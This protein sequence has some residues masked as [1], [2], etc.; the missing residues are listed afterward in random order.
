MKLRLFFLLCILYLGGQLSAADW[1]IIPV[2]ISDDLSGMHFTDE[3][4][5]FI[6][7]TSGSIYHLQKSDSGWV[8]EEQQLNRPV[9]GV[10]FD[11]NGKDG[12]AYGIKGV[13]F[14]TNDSGK[15][16]KLDTLNES[17]AFGGLT[18][19]DDGSVIL[20]G[21]DYA[22]GAGT[23]GI[24]LKST[25]KCQTWQPLNVKGK[26]F[27]SLAESPDGKLILT[28]LENIYLSKN[29]GASW[30]AV[31]VPARGYVQATAIYGDN[32]IMIGKG[33]YLALS[34]DGG[35]N[36]EALPILDNKRNFNDLLMLDSRRA[37]IVGTKGEILYTDDAGHNWIP[38]PCGAPD[39]L[40][41]IERVGNKLFVCGK[42]GG[43]VYT[44]I[45]D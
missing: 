34:D 3:N 8:F 12:I 40:A 6:T 27:F 7:S 25:D 11:K 20:I 22:K 42:K 41:D 45:D 36:W 38:E 9:K 2:D 37:Y 13:L 32:G 19:L 29:N 5:G 26:R 14:K 16:W 10:R 33:G 1:H 23:V 43:L 30:Q 15:T 24:A 35:E 21:I 4:N 39:D 44:E 31:K 28:S 18:Y 17:Y